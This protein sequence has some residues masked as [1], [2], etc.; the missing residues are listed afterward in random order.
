MLGA[1]IVDDLDEPAHSV[2]LDLIQLLAW[3]PDAD[4]GA[5]G[6]GQHGVVGRPYLWV[7]KMVYDGMVR[8]ANANLAIR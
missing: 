4:D 3:L 8:A 2:F 1:S 7:L 6:N 5:H